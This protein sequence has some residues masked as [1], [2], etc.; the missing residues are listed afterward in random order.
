[1]NNQ[2]LELLKKSSKEVRLVREK[3]D[4]K[5]AKEKDSIEKLIKKSR[6]NAIGL[7]R[8]LLRKA[9]HRYMD[10]P[11]SVLISFTFVPDNCYTI[12]HTILSDSE[13]TGV[14]GTKL[15]KKHNE[16]IHDYSDKNRIVFYS[17]EGSK[18]IPVMIDTL[19]DCSFD[20]NDIVV[21]FTNE[22]IRNLTIE[23]H[24]NRL[25]GVLYDKFLIALL[26]Y[27]YTEVKHNTD[28][29]NDYLERLSKNAQLI[30]FDCYKKLLKEY[31]KNNNESSLYVC[32]ENGNNNLDSNMLLFN[33]A[34]LSDQII[35][36]SYNNECGELT[37]VP[38]QLSVLRRLFEQDFNIGFQTFL[39]NN[40]NCIIKFDTALFEEGLIQMN[41]EEES[42]IIP[43]NRAK[44]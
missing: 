14:N 34:S 23:A 12:T 22:F 21:N 44:K 15:A 2:V 30:Y 31:E 10:D 24:E 35:Y 27:A 25:H 43:I 42:N 13:L 4:L 28:E 40:V 33:K 26:Q 20:C 39:F 1:M 41:K 29:M 8:F 38:V 7:Y 16:N 18:P 6:K 3:K 9:I 11:A 19:D 32:I 17:E 36:G 37:F 5:K